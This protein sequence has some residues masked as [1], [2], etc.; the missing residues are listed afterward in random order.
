MKQ[1]PWMAMAMALFFLTR[2]EAATPAAAQACVGGVDQFCNQSCAVV[3]GPLNLDSVSE[4]VVISTNGGICRQ[5][6]YPNVEGVWDVSSVRFAQGGRGRCGVVGSRAEG[7]HL[8][9][10]RF[11][12]LKATYGF[13]TENFQVTVKSRSREARYYTTTFNYYFCIS[14][15]WQVH[16][17]P[18]DWQQAVQRYRHCTMMNQ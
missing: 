6:S 3:M 10:Y 17:L 15:F 18:R 8:E 11:A 4:V 14:Q 5:W 1:G 7:V 9:A 2:P 13:C 12:D 16:E